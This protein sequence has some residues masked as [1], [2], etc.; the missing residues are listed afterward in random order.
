MGYW[1]FGEGLNMKSNLILLED[2]AA[3]FL[4]I[5]KDLLF[6]YIKHAP[7]K[8]LGDEKTLEYD[9][10]LAGFYQRDL[11]SWNDYLWEP[12]SSTSQDRP[13][14]P[15]YIE[16]Y[17]HTECGGQCGFCGKGPPLENAHIE[18][19]SNSRSHHHHNLIRLCT[20]CHSKYDDGII[21]KEAI[22]D[23]KNR[24]VN[25]IK[26]QLRDN[27]GSIFGNKI[28]YLPQPNNIFLGR[29]N[30]L[31]SLT[32]KLFSYRIVSLSGI[33]GIGKTQLLLQA[34]K[35]LKDTP[36]L[37]INV[38]TCKNVIDLEHTLSRALVTEYNIEF[39]DLVNSQLSMPLANLKVRIVFDGLDYIAETEWDQT[40]DFLSMLVKYTNFLTLAITTRVGFE[41]LEVDSSTM[42]LSALAKDDSLSVLK[43]YLKDSTISTLHDEMYLIAQFCDG[44]PLSLLISTSLIRYYKE[45]Q[46]VIDL[47]NKNGA[48]SL[49]V[50]KRQIHNRSSSL[51]T[52][53]YSVYSILNQRQ[54]EILQ[55]L[56]HYPAGCISQY[57]SLWLEKENDENFILELKDFSFITE[58]P[59]DQL[60]I[61][62]LYVLN[63]VREFIKAQA[64][65]DHNSFGFSKI[66]RDAYGLLVIE[67]CILGEKLDTNEIQYGL[68]RFDSEFPNFLDYI[69]KE[70]ERLNTNAEEQCKNDPERVEL[71]NFLDCI[72]ELSRYCFIRGLL[73][74]GIYIVKTGISTA[75]EYSDYERVVTL[76]LM[77]NNIYSRRHD[78]QTIEENIYELSLLQK[79]QN[80]SQYSKASIALGLGDL[81]LK[82]NDFTAAKDFFLEAERKLTNLIQK[83]N[84]N[85]VSLPEE[86][87]KNMQK[88]NVTGMLGNTLLELGRL[89]E[90]TNKPREALNYNLKALKIFEDMNDYTNLGQ[91]FHHIG[92]CYGELDN[93][94]KA[95]Q[96]YF[97][98][99]NIFVLLNSA[100]YISNS[101]S[102]IGSIIVDI[103]LPQEFEIVLTPDILRTGLH[104]IQV[105]IISFVETFHIHKQT[106]KGNGERWAVELIYKV[107]S[108]VKL[109]SFTSH[110]EIL[111]RWAVEMKELVQ[112]I[113][114]TQFELEQNTFT[115]LGVSP[116]DDLLYF[117]DNIS[118]IALLVVEIK[119]N[120]IPKEEGLRYLVEACERFEML[121]HIFRTRAWFSAWLKHIE[122]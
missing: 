79:Q 86:S 117:T 35:E 50:P 101:L 120:K 16:R 73:D 116:T 78:Q 37:W 51:D 69:E 90:Q 71:S 83:E 76:N 54:K 40:I 49:N 121:D 91:C 80:L 111:Y 115:G 96:F 24:L 95:L 27:L 68:D 64:I 118:Y 89:F 3:L 102:E 97:K 100:Q 112:P 30:E 39:T 36:I 53:L 33:G 10:K 57:V 5:T 42:V 2:K 56:S 1:C 41:I 28:F 62:R 92:N 105:E 87:F 22:L 75:K 29:D 74:Y 107:F 4:G 103:A 34:L 25:R 104:D 119:A 23:A 59:L 31:K 18:S 21:S 48:K 9:E 70:Q 110:T 82:K 19:F 114:Q 52:C 67:S 43:A 65:T 13:N 94:S 77:L 20:N 17:L 109:V 81:L 88:R 6:S 45:V 113:I 72:F 98:A 44:H 106:D 38:E 15:K 60:D 85:V 46:P 99:L 26:A 11:E 122:P 12:W 7:K 61:K 66:Q 32:N 108:L 55:F 58:L 63:P 14:I 8:N 93:K 47:L 84:Q